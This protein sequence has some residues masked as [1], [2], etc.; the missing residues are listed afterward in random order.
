VTAYHNKDGSVEWNSRTLTTTDI[1]GTSWTVNT[2]ADTAET[3]AMLDT[4]QSNRGGLVD[5]NAEV[6]GL[7]VCAE[8]YLGMLGSSATLK[9]YSDDSVQGF[10]GTAICTGIRET[11]EL[12]DVGKVTLSFEGAGQLSYEGA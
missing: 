2:S 4:W 3:T 10:S 11:M 5:W 1:G 7:T 8:N 12:N 9:C 6:V